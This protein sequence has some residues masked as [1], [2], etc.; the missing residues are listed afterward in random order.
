MRKQVDGLIL[1]SGFRNQ[2]VL[3]SLISN[4]YPLIM[5]ADHHPGMSI[6]TVSVDDYKGGYLAA[7][8]LLELGHR[9]IGIIGEN[10]RSSNLRI[11]GY[12]DACADYQ[13]PVQ[14]ELTR[15]SDA[16]VANGQEHVHTSFLCPNHRQH[17]LSLMICLLLALFRRYKKKVCVFRQSFRLSALTIRSWL[18]RRCQR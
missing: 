4:Q 18:K 2:A 10:V 7:A 11:Y 16:S 14:E 17:C 8:H 3:E 13:V 9:R 15:R 6:P 5:F 1:A 12:R